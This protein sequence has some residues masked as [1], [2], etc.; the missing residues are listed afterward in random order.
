MKKSYTLKLEG[1]QWTECLDKAFELKK[2][3]A[4][5]DGFRKGQVTKEIS[6]LKKVE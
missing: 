4:K 6:M 3:D 1:K 5:V 2:K